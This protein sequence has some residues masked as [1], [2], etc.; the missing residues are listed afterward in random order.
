MLSNDLDAD[1]DPLSLDGTSTS[2]A[3]ELGVSVRESMVLLT[4][5]SDEGVY[6]AQYTVSDSRGGTDT[7]TL[8][9]QVLRDAPLLNPV[10]V[11]D[12]VTLEQV[13]A[14]GQVTVPVLDNDIDA[15]G[16]PWDLTVS[17][18]EP[19]VEVVDQ[20]IHLAVEDEQRM[21][22]YTV[23]DADG[24]TGSAVVIVP[25]RSDLRPRLNAATVPVTVPADTT[26]EGWLSAVTV[27]GLPAIS[28]LCVGLLSGV[29]GLGLLLSGLL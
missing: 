9:V 15:D 10:G 17:T 2:D 11:D 1:G 7:G 3:A 12:Y 13:D 14:N 19:G 6:S 28:R 26:T 18:S 25:A 23:T 16:T 21:V 4:L 8:T 29:A 20:T 24:L 27:L 5:P 22:L